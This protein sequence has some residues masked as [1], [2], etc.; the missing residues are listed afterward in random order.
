VEPKAANDA[1]CQNFEDEGH[2]FIALETAAQ[3][4]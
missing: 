1:A 4:T 2:W 3:A